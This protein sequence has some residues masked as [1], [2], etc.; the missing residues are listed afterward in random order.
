MKVTLA[1]I[2]SLI[3]NADVSVDISKIEADMSLTEAG[4]DSLEMFN[5]FLAIEEQ[6]NIKVADKDIDSLDTINNILAYLRRN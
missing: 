2:L 3:E 6:Y 5:V 4:V 1:D